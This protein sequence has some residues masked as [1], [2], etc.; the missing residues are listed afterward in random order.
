MSYF[1]SGSFGTP[2]VFGGGK[3]NVHVEHD[4]DAPNCGGQVGV[5]ITAQH[6]LPQPPQEP[7]ALLTG[8]GHLDQNG[9]ASCEANVDF[10][11]TYTRIGD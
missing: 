10:D 5:K 6:P 2:M 11:E 9:S 4:Q 7:I 1:H 3:W 8:H